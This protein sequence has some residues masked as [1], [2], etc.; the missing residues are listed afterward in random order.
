[1]TDIL[2]RHELS[3]KL[4]ELESRVD[5]KVGDKIPREPRWEADRG[6]RA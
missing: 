2:L 1:M 6:H 4:A 3:L 5:V